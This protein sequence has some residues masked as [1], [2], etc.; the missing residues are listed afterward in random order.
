M[1]PPGRWPDASG[2]TTNEWPPLY[3][4]PVRPHWGWGVWTALVV[5]GALE[6]VVALGALLV[7]NFG[8]ST[9]CNGTPTMRNVH[10]GELSLVVALA[11]G[12]VPWAVAV[13]LSPRRIPLVVAG[14]LAVSPLLVGMIAGLDPGF[15]DN[16]FC[17]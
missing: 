11:V 10:A 7:I 2:M 1:W 8:N 15:W 6:F 9:T 13:V 3:E 17:F 5:A 4:R 14:V 16:G 12:A